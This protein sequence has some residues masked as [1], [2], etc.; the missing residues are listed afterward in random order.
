MRIDDPPAR[1][2]RVA[3]AAAALAAL[4][5]CAAIAAK[6][7]LAPERYAP[8]A[9]NRAWTPSPDAA[10]DYA[11]PP[12]G[13]VPDRIPPQSPSAPA[14]AASEY[15]LTALIDI[16]LTNNPA[17]RSAW[18]RAR[19]AAAS[20]GASRAAYYP[21]LT[22][23]APAGYSRRIEELPAQTGVVKEWYAEP[24]L[25]LTYTLLDF[26]RR[27]ADDEIARQQLAAANFAF[28]RELQTVV[29]DTQRGFY[30]LAAAKAG[31]TAAEENLA[32]AKTDADAVRSRVELGLATQ[33]ALLLARERVAQSE[34]DLANARLFVHEGQAALAE[35]LGVAANAP[36][37]IQ[38]LQSQQVPTSLGSQVDEL[39]A[40]AVRR[41]P[42]LTAQVATLKARES[43]VDRAR[44]EFYPNLT[45]LANYG[46]QMW[47]FQFN[48]PPTEKP[49]QPQYTGQ[50]AL[51]W[52]L[53][54]GFQRL[55]QLRKAEADRAAAVASLQTDEVGTIAEV[56]R[57]YHEFEATRSKYDYAQALLA[58][59]EEAYA[60]TLDTYR[61]GL[62]TIVELLTAGRD[63][64]N[65]RYTVIQSTAD[66]LTASA[67]VAY[68]VGAVE[69]PRG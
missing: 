32:L 54:T 36:F 63:L 40:D 37:E 53:F 6:P 69:M 65:A 8:A 55:N 48:G 11:I 10:P 30:A 3:A 41:R 64:A 43:G 13:R 27:N 5:G 59:T 9:A 51:S 67:A 34:F 19:A 23:D 33:P 56:W 12:A 66:L 25:Q 45:A 39:I 38:R 49:L 61:Q 20:Y 60:A 21:R 2:P 16:S 47:N 42:D 18:E 52:D 29:F 50:I 35:A 14:D 57:A 22:A 7:E 15:G 58:A 46:E 17:T 24:V 1:R 68:S 31:V 26:G 28:D 62:S 4:A 44:A